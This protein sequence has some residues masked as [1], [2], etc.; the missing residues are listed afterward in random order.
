MACYRD[1]FTFYSYLG[2]NNCLSI[3]CCRISKWILRCKLVYA[4]LL[5]LATGL[6]LR[7]ARNSVVAVAVV[8]CEEKRPL[9]YPTHRTTLILINGLD[10]IECAFC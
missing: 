3:L 8:L 5:D 2:L 7:M 1:S 4:V 9:I 6:R 10:Q